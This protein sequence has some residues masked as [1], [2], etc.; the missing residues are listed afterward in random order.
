MDASAAKVAAALGKIPGVVDV[1]DG[2]VEANP[3]LMATVDPTRAGRVGLTT[4]K[5]ADQVN[6]AMYGDVVTQLLQGDRQVG[7][8]VRYPAAY[9]SDLGH[10][11]SLPIRAP[12]DF[13]LPLSALAHVDRV[14]GLTELNRDDQR[15]VDYVSG[16]LNGRDLG[17]V[18]RDVERTMGKIELP[19]GFTYLLGGQFQSQNEA[20]RGLVAV[21]GLAIVLV[22]AVMLFQFGSFTAPTVIMLVMPLSIFGVVLGLW[23]TSTPFNVS[24]FMGLVMLVGIVVKNGILLLDRAQKAEQEGIFSRRSCASGRAHETP[25]DSDDHANCHPRPG[26]SVPGPWRGR[27][28]AEAVGGCRDWRAQPVD[29]IHALLCSPAVRGPAPP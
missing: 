24:S 17:S 20:F 23:V 21:L 10:L 18:Q 26:A 29:H 5:V 7:V 8:R 13:V 28:D 22:F 25:S 15:R 14:P 3:D 16:Q 4:D 12:G 11:G 9:R 19:A 6:A 2:V 27:G 1:S